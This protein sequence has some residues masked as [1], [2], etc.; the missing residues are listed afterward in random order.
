LVLD[1]ADGSSSLVTSLS[2]TMELLEGNV[3]AA[4]ANGVH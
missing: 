2:T 1:G 4:A 3:D